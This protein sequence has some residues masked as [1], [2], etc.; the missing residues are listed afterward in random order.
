MNLYAD[1]TFRIDTENAFKIGTHVAG[2]EQKFGD[3]VKLTLGEPDFPVP[4]H[5]KD[6]I[7]RQIDLDNTH[8]CDPKGVLSLRQAIAHQV[9]ATRG[10]DVNPERVVVFPGGKPPIGFVQQVYCNPGNEVIYPSPG[11]PI[12]ESFISY[13]DGVPVPL[14]LDESSN[15]TFSS[16]QLSQLISPSTKLIYLNSP[17]N[18]TGGVVSP[19]QLE[20]IAATILDRCPA[21]VRVY[22]DEI[23]ENIMFDNN[24][25][26]SIASLPGMESRTIIASGFSK[27]YSWTGGRIG[28][29]VF[30]T[31]SE[32][33]VFKNLNINYF[34]CVTPYNQ[35]AARLAL[36]SPLSV[37]AVSKMVSTFQERRDVIWERLN[38]MDG[39][40]C[41]KPL[42]AFYLFPNISG[43]CE[44]LGL[45]DYYQ[46]MSAAD[47][48]L[49]SPAGLFQMFALYC[50]RVAVMDRKSFGRL[51]SEGQHYIRLSIASDLAVLEDGIARLN[52]G[53]QDNEGINHFLD[54]RPDLQ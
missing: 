22:S 48:E 30:P 37:P 29:A 33:D 9:S 15:F 39:I 53:A 26:H 23:Y 38:R 20:A 34:S 43:I 2:V 24:K 51:G 19:E 54:T 11:F 28:Y 36:E 18:P 49:T 21:E 42:G 52:D 4:I 14:H 16:D 46:G 50:H 5:I 3:V 47:K 45:I 12:Y 10:L 17:S 27:T 40:T 6:E 41:Q 13:V 35:E 32:A 31:E 25:H 7:K 1:R 8:Y 44:N